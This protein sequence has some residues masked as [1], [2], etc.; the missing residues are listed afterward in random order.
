MLFKRFLFNGEIDISF[1]DNGVVNINFVLDELWVWDFKLL[2]NGKMY[3]VFL[4][5]N[6]NGED[7]ILIIKYLFFGE[8]DILFS[9]NGIFISFIFYDCYCRI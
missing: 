9:D 5:M 8:L 3:V 7:L 2:D 6:F 1:G 4:V